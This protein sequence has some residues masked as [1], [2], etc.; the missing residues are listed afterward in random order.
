MCTKDG[1]VHIIKHCDK[2]EQCVYFCNT[3]LFWK[4][5]VISGVR[6]FTKKT[7]H[8]K[9]LNKIKSFRREL[10]SFL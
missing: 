3:R 10:N 7:D 2:L 4:I 6:P 8:L 1:G 9:K 5:L